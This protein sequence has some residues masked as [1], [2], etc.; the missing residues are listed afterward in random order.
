M[1]TNL[2]KFAISFILCFLAAYAGSLFTP[3]PG[4]SWYYTE[5]NRPEW[6]PPDWLFPPVWSLLFLMMSISFWLVLKK[7]TKDSKVTFAVIAFCVQLLLN[8]AWSAA[9]FGMQ[10]PQT[11]MIVILLLWMAIVL[12]IVQFKKISAVAAYLLVPYLLWVSFA[13][14]LNFTIWQLNP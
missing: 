6:N 3:E 11:G 12:T 10:N 2:L 8:M 14:Y 13:S 5:L 4:S 7:A 9:F 1:N